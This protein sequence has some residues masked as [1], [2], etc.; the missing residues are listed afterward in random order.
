MYIYVYIHIYIYVY[1]YIYIYTYIYIHKYIYILHEARRAEEGQ[2]G[3]S[4]CHTMSQLSLFVTYVKL[5]IC[6]GER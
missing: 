2:K 1:I 3:G 4:D 5:P 6:L